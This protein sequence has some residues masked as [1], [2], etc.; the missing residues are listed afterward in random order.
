MET[1]TVYNS[2]AE[3]IAEMQRTNADMDETFAFLAPDGTVRYTTRC[4]VQDT[5][6]LLRDLATA[7][8]S[9]P[10]PAAGS[11]GTSSTTRHRRERSTKQTDR[12]KKASSALS[13]EE[14]KEEEEEERGPPKRAQSP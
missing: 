5:E 11:S 2:Y 7:E 1:R 9:Q 14:K 8:L 10:Q 4:M 3:V 13:S 6:E 12:K